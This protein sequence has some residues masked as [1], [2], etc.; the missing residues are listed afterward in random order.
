MSLV[1]VLRAQ[2]PGE[3]MKR[4]AQCVA[5]MLLA[6]TLELLPVN[7]VKPSSDAMLFVLR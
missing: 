5:T 4:S 2:V 6:S 7:P 3:E 1:T